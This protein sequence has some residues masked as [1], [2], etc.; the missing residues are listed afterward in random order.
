MLIPTQRPCCMDSLWVGMSIQC[1]WQGDCTGHLVGDEVFPNAVRQTSELQIFPIKCRNAGRLLTCCNQSES[2]YA[3]YCN[4]SVSCFFAKRG[5]S[6]LV[7][8]C[9]FSGYIPIKTRLL[10]TYVI[11][12]YCSAATTQLFVSKLSSDYTLNVSNSFQFL[13]VLKT[14]LQF[15]QVYL[16]ESSYHPRL[17]SNWQLNTISSLKMESSYWHIIKFLIHQRFSATIS[18]KIAS[19]LRTVVPWSPVTVF[20]CVTAA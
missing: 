17:R 7:S 11:I 12:N 10:C 4:S 18:N 20:P 3:D 9:L 13:C 6:K 19:S 15:S 1:V 16:S 5:S 2:M 8:K 14:D